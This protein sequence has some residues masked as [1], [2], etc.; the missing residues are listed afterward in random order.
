MMLPCIKSIYCDQAAPV[1]LN[2]LPA[3]RQNEPAWHHLQP[4]LGCQ[5]AE[6]IIIESQSKRYDG[7]PERRIHQNIR[8]VGCQNAEFIMNSQRKHEPSVP[9]HIRD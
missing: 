1:K 8:S 3:R 6:F 7:V 4:N 9:E 2:L 5:N